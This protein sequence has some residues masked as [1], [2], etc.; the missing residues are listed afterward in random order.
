M[1][2]VGFL[3]PER[4]IV[5][6]RR[7]STKFF[8]D[9]VRR[10]SCRQRDF[11]DSD[12]WGMISFDYIIVDHEMLCAIRIMIRNCE[13]CR[14]CHLIMMPSYVGWGYPPNNSQLPYS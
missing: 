10:R 9:P 4:N 14:V 13:K 8:C 12:P 2:V 1:Q 3:L 6:V 5:S 7:T 11:A